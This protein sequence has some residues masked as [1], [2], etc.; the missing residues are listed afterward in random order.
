[1]DVISS[2]ISGWRV[3]DSM[4]LPKMMPMPTPAPAAPRPPPTPRA[5]DLPA[6]ETSPSRA[7]RMVETVL[8]VAPWFLV[9]FGDGA[10]EIDG[11]E[12]GEDE[13]LQRGDQADLEEVERDAQRQRDPAE[14]G[15]AQQHGQRAAHEED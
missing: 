1:I 5:I 10:A 8:M 2:R 6:F 12:G 15:D 9:G 14:G 4:T 13:R 3:T 7:A 11:S